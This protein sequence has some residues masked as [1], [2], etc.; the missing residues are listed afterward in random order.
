MSLD[1]TLTDQYRLPLKLD[2]YPVVE[3]LPAHFE[4]IYPKFIEFIESYYRDYDASGS[5]AESLN[6]LQHNRDM[7]DVTPQ[8]LKLIGQE[9]FLG[10]DYTESF[11]D[12]PTAIQISN[13]LYRS[14]GT[15]FS[16]EQFFKMFFGFDVDV[17][18]GRNEI[19]SVGDP[20]QEKLLFK[21]EYRPVGKD[22][23]GNDVNF[24]YPGDKLKFTF[25]DG[26][27]QVYAL[28]A[29]PKVEII[30][31]LYI[32]KVPGE[33]IDDVGAGAPPLAFYVTKTAV[34]T[35]FNFYYLL[36][37]NIDYIVDYDQR[38]IVFLAPGIDNSVQPG[39]PWLDYLAVN[40]EIAPP[41]QDLDSDGTPFGPLRYPY[42]RL[43]TTRE[44][45]AG[46]PIGADVG[47]KR[48]TDNGYYQMFSLLI[49]TP[50]AVSSWK[51]VY[52]D[53]VHP[54]GMYLGG[55]VLIET[56]SSLALKGIQTSTERYDID[57]VGIGE[58]ADEAYAEVTELNVKPK[59]SV[60]APSD[61][62]YEMNDGNFLLP[63]T[64]ESVSDGSIEI[65]FN[66]K[67]SSEMFAIDRWLFSATV[68]GKKYGLV[69]PAASENDLVYRYVE[70]TTLNYVD[71]P[72]KSNVLFGTTYTVTILSA[73]N[74]AI[75][76]TYIT[77]NGDTSIA[78]T[79]S[80][81]YPRVDAIGDDFVG[82]I[83]GLY[84]NDP[85]EST[86]QIFYPMREG[87][88]D[89]LFGYK[90]SGERFNYTKNISIQNGT[91]SLPAIPVWKGSD[92][93][94]AEWT[95]AAASGFAINTN[96]KIASPVSSKK[97]LL[98]DNNNDDRGLYVSADNKLHYAYASTDGVT[99]IEL[100]PM[101]DNV[102]VSVK[103]EHLT[104][105]VTITT[106]KNLLSQNTVDSPVAPNGPVIIN[107]ALEI[108]GI[109]WN[110]DLIEGSNTRYY[111]MQ[112]GSGTEMQ[113]YDQDGH[114]TSSQ[115]AISS[116]GTW[117]TR[118]FLLKGG[119]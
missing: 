85:Y 35:T 36:R 77:V 28:G 114:T 7:A 33:Y 97:L 29:K 102:E 78:Q 86:N 43:E 9:L 6:E 118:D 10:E 117:V 56:I 100:F 82:A 79:P 109:M 24:L 93:G 103:I 37:E 50:I 38:N 2:K 70:E 74:G 92:I 61:F 12:Q 64:W 65:T 76:E 40:G 98:W 67:Q 107:S 11:L 62:V 18:Y 108:E 101:E 51:D 23:S 46:S 4:T 1:K 17:N 72:V 30:P 26:T 55:E 52:K 57:Y 96:I 81:Y 110:L 58:I 75:K 42:A 115:N 106:E 25:G 16:I 69:F 54:S 8:L 48:I 91:W 89:L 95:S 45:P 19:F 119:V 34:K 71:V 21:S 32:R 68:G 60:P 31:S 105:K 39:D 73:L 111:P 66:R 80:E 94:I 59:P 20:T 49:K 5:P 3:T 116:N 112:D 99:D 41:G 53:F 22:A 83:W 63:Q 13:L 15:S 113:A 84:L 14:K 27:I 104:S 47:D 88:G 87:R 90:I 44:F